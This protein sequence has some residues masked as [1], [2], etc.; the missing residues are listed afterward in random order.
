M[1]KITLIL[2]FLSL[3]IF[4]AKG[5]IIFHDNFSKKTAEGWQVVDVNFPQSTSSIW[6]VSEGA[7]VHF[8]EEDVYSSSYTF[9]TNG[10][11]D[12]SDYI[13]TLKFKQDLNGR[14]GVFFRFKDLNNTYRFYT[15]D[16]LR[17]KWRWRAIVLDK[18]SNG[19]W[20]I[21]ASK[22]E[23]YREPKWE[24]LRIVVSGKRIFVY[25]NEKLL[26][27][28][29]D[30]KP[31]TKGKIALYS[32][33]D[34]YSYF[35]NICIYSINQPWVSYNYLSRVIPLGK[36]VPFKIVITNYSSSPLQNISIKVEGNVK[37]IPSLPEKINIG[38]NEEKTF[39]LEI[40]GEKTGPGKLLVYKGGEIIGFK[41]IYITTEEIAS[42]IPIFGD[43][44]M[45][46]TYSDGRNTPLEMF[47]QCK[48]V[49]LDV[50]CISDHGN[51]L[52]SLAAKKLTE[53]SGAHMVVIVGEENGCDF[54]NTHILS[55]NIPENFKYKV[56]N[57]APKEIR[58]DIEKVM[59]WAKSQGMVLVQAHPVSE[60]HK[61]TP[62]E[63]LKTTLYLL[64]NNLIDG[65]EIITTGELGEN[66][67]KKIKYTTQFYE[68][69]KKKGMLYPITASTDSHEKK[70]LGKAKTLLFVK[71]FT[72]EGVLEAIK[73]GKTVGMFI[74]SPNEISIYGPDELVGIA[75]IY[76][77]DFMPYH[78]E[79]AK[80]E[81]HLLWMYFGGHPEKKKEIKKLHKRWRELIKEKLPFVNL[82]NY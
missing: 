39:D 57:Y 58:N 4:S 45:H 11:N 5:E 20:E 1:K 35:D 8:P 51:I 19:K 67:F 44:H 59:K 76:I 42:L 9:S 79:I 33:A 26:F 41:K 34:K 18:I 68:N 70:F 27:K 75:K 47:I 15:F 13:L 48:R 14:T 55:Y 71:S 74:P 80:D 65:F 73:T 38:G 82:D 23:L 37:I 22:W 36:K 3:F 66:V 24:N 25:L 46:T 69:L 56:K 17:V 10:K 61:G 7:Y 62:E 30:E 63:K 12:W 72:V 21:L 49:G 40:E 32:A 60:L 78:D 50:I 77:E 29:V 28:V 16:K 54:P 81:A 31:L 52:G 6:T 2:F 64:Q 43:F 53:S